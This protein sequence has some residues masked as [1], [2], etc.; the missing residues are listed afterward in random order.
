MENLELAV[1]SGE[2]SIGSVSIL[3]MSVSS[4]LLVGD[5]VRTHLVSVFE[6]PLEAPSNGQDGVSGDG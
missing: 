4:V 5:L 3:A 1:T 6:S 2:L